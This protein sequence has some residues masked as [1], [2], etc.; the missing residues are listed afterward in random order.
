MNCS[1]DEME[2]ITMGAE[3]G[4]GLQEVVVEDISVAGE[5]CTASVTH[6]NVKCCTVVL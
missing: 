3:W 4:S 2:D 1:G 6:I 5:V